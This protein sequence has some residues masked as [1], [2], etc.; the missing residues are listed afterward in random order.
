MGS[1]IETHIEEARFR[2]PVLQVTLHLISLGLVP[3]DNLLDSMMAV[4]QDRRLNM[5]DLVNAVEIIK[6]WSSRS[7]KAREWIVQQ[8]NVHEYPRIREL[9]Q[10]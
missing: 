6:K 7:A 9:C 5:H 1:F 8:G 3:N 10:C 2:R 4:A